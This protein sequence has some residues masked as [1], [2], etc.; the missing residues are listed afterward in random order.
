MGELMIEF[1]AGLVVGL[2]V[3]FFIFRQALRRV[4]RS[5]LVLTVTNKSTEA[6]AFRGALYGTIPSWSVKMTPRKNK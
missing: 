5:G 3:G 4:A 2:A 1:F 6:I